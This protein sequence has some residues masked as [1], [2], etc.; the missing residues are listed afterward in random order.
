MKKIP[1]YILSGV[2][3]AATVAS[4]AVMVLINE[5]YVSA[6]EDVAS[7][8]EYIEELK[9]DVA[10]EE[11]TTEDEIKEFEAERDGYLKEIEEQEKKNAGLEKQFL[12]LYDEEELNEIKAWYEEEPEDDE[13]EEAEVPSAATE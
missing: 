13:E 4:I 8:K 5:D 1:A 2:C 11:K 7:E 12:E 6:S 10:E 9:A 3:A